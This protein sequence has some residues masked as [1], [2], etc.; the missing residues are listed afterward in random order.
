MDAFSL[1]EHFFFFNKESWLLLVYFLSILSSST[2]CRAGRVNKVNLTTEDPL[3]GM[4]SQEG[5]MLRENS[6]REE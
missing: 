2:N 6:T 3:Q 1:I 5:M 4:G